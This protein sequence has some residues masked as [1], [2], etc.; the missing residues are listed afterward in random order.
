MSLAGFDQPVPQIDEDS[1]L[2]RDLE[3][4]ETEDRSNP[5]VFFKVEGD[6][7]ITKSI[8]KL[9]TDYLKSVQVS[10]E[11]ES[12]KV[13]LDADPLLAK[14]KSTC[15]TLELE[16]IRR[17]RNRMHAKKTRLRK[18]KMIQDMETVSNATQLF[19]N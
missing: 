12:P 13:S 8:E 9:K 2:L 18:K 4:S 3:D 5:L 17:E 10:L 15:S 7:Y 6:D 14:D 1:T 16:M 19:C 11:G